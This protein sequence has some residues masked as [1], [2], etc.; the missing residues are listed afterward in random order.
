MYRHHDLIKIHGHID[1]KVAARNIIAEFLVCYQKN[2]ISILA[3]E[4]VKNR[5]EVEVI[6]YDNYEECS[7]FPSE[8]FIYPSTEDQ[9]TLRYTPKTSN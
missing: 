7:I 3:V 2:K 8:D 5:Y 4:G 1:N 9:F 6:Y